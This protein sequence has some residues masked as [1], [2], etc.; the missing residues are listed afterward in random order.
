[1]MLLRNSRQHI[2]NALYFIPLVQDE[3][4]WLD[5]NEPT[6]NKPVVTTQILVQTY[7]G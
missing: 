3:N 4:S 1:M 6:G 5:L 7:K 2:F